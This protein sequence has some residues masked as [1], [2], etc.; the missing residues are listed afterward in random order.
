[1]GMLNTK[2]DW[3]RVPKATD[4]QGRYRCSKCREWK[5]PALF[6][7]NKYQTTGLNYACKACMKVHVRKYNLPAKYGISPAKF[8]EMLLAQG[9][10]CACCRA[11]FNMEGKI[12]ER[13]CVDHNH[14]SDEVRDLLCG[15]CNL[16]AGN[17]QDSSVRAE[18]LAAYLKKWNC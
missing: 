5:A 8:A 16:A 14:S 17:V 10:K 9:G 15:R 4:E 18:Q 13:P 2:R 6:S 1:M 11:Q 12:S 3:G 7:K